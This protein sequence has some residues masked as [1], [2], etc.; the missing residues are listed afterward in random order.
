M[1]DIVL[2]SVKT[3]KKRR[4]DIEFLEQLF[5]L[6]RDQRSR[7]SLFLPVTAEGVKIAGYAVSAVLA[8]IDDHYILHLSSSECAKGIAFA[9][10]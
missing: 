8:S 10:N 7:S 1:S 6:I 2:F 5:W 9:S 3:R 4:S